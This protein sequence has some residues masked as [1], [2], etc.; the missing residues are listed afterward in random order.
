MR[1][2]SIRY[3]SNRKFRGKVNLIDKRSQTIEHQL[4]RLL[5]DA[6]QSSG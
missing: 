4:F 5:K 1:S 3:Q 2:T 6:W